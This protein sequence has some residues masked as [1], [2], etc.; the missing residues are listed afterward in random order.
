MVDAILRAFTVPG[1]PGGLGGPRSE[2][3]WFWIAD[4]HQPQSHDSVPV[5]GVVVPRHCSHNSLFRH[6]QRRVKSAAGHPNQVPLLISG[7]LSCAVLWDAVAYELPCL[8]NAV[9]RS[10]PGSARR[11]VV[12]DVPPHGEVGGHIA[13]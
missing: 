7:L 1:G 8:V 13:A 10:D 4:L 6:P 11:D 2:S 3:R 9:L 12:L 5:D